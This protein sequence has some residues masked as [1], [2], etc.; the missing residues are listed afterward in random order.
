[1]D[2]WGPKY[3]EKEGKEIAKADAEEILR[4]LDGFFS[5]LLEVDE[6]HCKKMI[7]TYYSER[8][9]EVVGP[10]AEAIATDNFRALR[11]VEYAIEHL[12][13]VSGMGELLRD[14][15]RI[16]KDGNH[17]KRIYLNSLTQLHA[18]GFAHKELK[19]HIQAVEAIN[20]PVLSPRRI[21]DKSCDFRASDGHEESYFETKDSSAET[22]SE[23]RIKGIIHFDPMNER[24]I[25]DWIINRC[26]NAEKKGADYLICRV[27]VWDNWE[28]EER[29]FY[30]KWIREVFEVKSQPDKNEVVISRPS[31]TGQLKG[32]YIIKAFGYLRITFE[33]TPLS[34]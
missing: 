26:R 29:E 5:I 8:G 28:E 17:G 13:S 21:G 22:M 34:R 3:A 23:H 16:Q 27:P 7:Q 14:L 12:A 24:K 20:Q 4:N 9:I 33:A 31:G 15:A 30:G 18:V 6:K 10:L 19:L 25:G 1:M 2:F 32:I 11:H